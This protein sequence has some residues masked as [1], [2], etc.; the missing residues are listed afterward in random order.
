LWLAIATCPLCAQTPSEAQIE[1]ALRD[2]AEQLHLEFHLIKAGADQSK[3]EETRQK[4]MDLQNQIKEAGESAV[5][6]LIKAY[7]D[8]LQE[9]IKR[10]PYGIRKYLTIF[11][12]NGVKRDYEP[13]LLT[14]FL[15]RIAL[16]DPDPEIRR[17]AVEVMR[18][19]PVLHIE[20]LRKALDDKDDFV[21]SPASV[22]LSELRD[23]K[24][25]PLQMELI[26]HN[27]L[28]VRC[29]MMQAILD[30]TKTTNGQKL[31][32]L[33]Q[34]LDGLKVDDAFTASTVA[35]LERFTGLSFGRYYNDKPTRHFLPSASHP[36]Q[37]SSE[38][39]AIID[40]WKSWFSENKSRLNWSDR[41]GRFLL[42]LQ[43]QLAKADVRKM[44]ETCATSLSKMSSPTMG[45][46]DQT[47]K[48]A[49]FDKQVSE[50]IDSLDEN[51][52]DEALPM[53]NE[54]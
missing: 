20:A 12:W 3:I 1:R 47:A 16:T 29:D 48:D 34:A 42:R 27:S 5:P 2:Y 36:P 6:V 8:A 23:P 14:A 11:L 24:F 54:I 50:I 25:I 53:L 43:K 19:N 13:K 10:N 46:T 21:Q 31:H 39:Q 45:R 51:L 41:H 52:A 38:K 49:A 37:T 35:W 9:G 33:G 17:G 26:N 40:K 30:N 44:L 22:Y 4:W 32:A 28:M 18:L 15:D 7:D